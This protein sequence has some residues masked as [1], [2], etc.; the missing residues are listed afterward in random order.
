[1]TSPI[2]FGV[3]ALEWRTS[4][5]RDDV[6]GPLGGILHGMVIDARPGRKF[7]VAEC[8]WVPPEGNPLGP[9][10][11]EVTCTPDAGGCKLRIRQS[12]YEPSVRW[13]RYYATTAKLWQSALAALKQY[14]ETGAANS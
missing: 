13:R 4:P 6:L 2:P 9:M 3:Y 14:A 5:H 11:L 1:V 8:W 7:A 12:G 10:A